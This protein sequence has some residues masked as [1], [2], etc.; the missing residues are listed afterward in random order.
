MHVPLTSAEY[1]RCCELRISNA[2]T[3]LF[4]FDF[5]L[6]FFSDYSILCRSLKSRAAPQSAR[7]SGCISAWWI[8]RTHRRWM[9]FMSNKYFIANR[10]SFLFR[11]SSFCSR[12]PKRVIFKWKSFQTSANPAGRVEQQNKLESDFSIF[13]TKLSCKLNFFT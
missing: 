5:L 6:S 2:R 3:K 13:N 7:V 9:K 10:N 11:F 12:K 1:L 4:Q 8:G